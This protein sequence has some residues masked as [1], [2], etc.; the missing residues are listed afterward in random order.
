MM[1]N[2]Q[3]NHFFKPSDFAPT[4]ADNKAI[5][6]VFLD[7]DGVLLTNSDGDSNRE[8]YNKNLPFI[9]SKLGEAYRDLDLHDIG[10]TLLFSKDAVANLRRLCEK[11]DSQI[12]I[13]SQWRLNS[14]DDR[15]RSL[16][17]LRL[18]FKLWDLDQLII[19][20]TPHRFGRDKE[21]QAWLDGYETGRI[22]SYVILD[23]I[24]LSREFPN[25]LV[26]TQDRMFFSEKHLDKALSILKS[27]ELHPIESST[28]QE[29]EYPYCELDE[30]MEIME[31]MP[32]DFQP[33]MIPDEI[34]F[35]WLGNQWWMWFG[36]M[37]QTIC[38]SIAAASPKL[39]AMSFCNATK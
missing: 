23:D 10:A 1:K 29:A 4:N 7:I 13:S 3:Q 30:M 14:D 22:N 33:N 25:N 17:R 5:N 2:R 12:V 35:H 16:K 9:Q 38:A 21:I 31:E 27:L 36:F 37:L 15:E 8:A 28:L 11:T 32:L 6:V 20:E 18:L 34:F 26:H 24:D 19:D 39:E